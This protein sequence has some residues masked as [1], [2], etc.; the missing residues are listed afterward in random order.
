M[1]LVIDIETNGLLDHMLDY[2]SFPYKLNNKARLWCVVLRNIDTDEVIAGVGKELTR[3]WF[4]DNL[5]QCTELIAHNGVKFDFLVLRLFGLLDYKI[6]FFGQ[7]STIFGKEVQ[8]VDTLVWSRLFYPDRFGG[9]G[10]K[11]WGERFGDHKGDFKQFDRYSQEMLDYCIQDTKVTKLVY[12]KL[13]RE[14]KSGFWDKS[15]AVE[16]KLAD[17][18]INREQYGFR[19]DTKLAYQCVEDLNNKIE[20]LRNKVNPL[21]PEKTLNKG[22]AK[23]LTPPVEKFKKDGN[24]TKNFINF[25]ERIGGE[26]DLETRTFNYD[27][28]VYPI[29]FNGCLKQTIKADIDDQDHVKMHMMNLGWKPTEWRQRNLVIDTSKRNLPY[30]K[31]IE[32]LNRWYND[33]INGKYTE[34]RF[35]EF[36]VPRDKLYDYLAEKLKE[37][38]P[39]FVPTSPSVKVTTE[40]VLCPDLVRLADKIEFAKYFALYTTYKHRRSSILGGDIDE[41]GNPT[42]GYLS[43]VRADGRI[44]TPA[45]EVGTNTNRYRHIG[46]CNIPRPS[47]IY[48][49]E[50]R[51]LFTCNDDEYELGFDFSSLENR[52]QGHHVL[53]YFGG[54]ELARLLIADKP[55]DLHTINAKKLG[56]SRDDA[57]SFTYAILYGGQPRKLSKMLGIS[58]AEAKD[59]YERFWDAV[60]ALK[61]LKAN[62]EKFWASTGKLYI[63][64]IDGRKIFTRQKHSLLNA[65]FQSN[66]V[67]SV[68]Y[69]IVKMFEYFEN[70]GYT[71]SPFDGQPDVIN[72]I[73][74]HDES[75]LAVRKTFVSFKVFDSE[76]EAENY[77][78]EFGVTS[79]FKPSS[80]GHAKKWYF[81]EPN[82]IS[83]VIE[84]SI[85]ETV[86]FLKLR[87][88]LGYEWV[89]HKNWGGAH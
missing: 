34:G 58:L 89:V 70:M 73:D 71:I 25:I 44:P 75:Q 88:P 1:R 82:E 54:E 47:S 57:K 74:Y 23:K 33:T 65:L 45:I 63:T 15:Y 53:K 48:G 3:Q 78:K 40:K 30:E 77:Q 10:L 36:D 20:D 79:E 29:S 22:E 59:L 50:L 32:A 21:L 49:T 8:I 26:I 16:L 64:A 80:V 28:V 87:V 85:N 37:D 14:Y 69:T 11:A 55:N 60:P 83:K 46:V 84:T 13:L 67:I 68:K 42:K 27:G 6:G 5:S 4:V 72:M 52:V 35:G 18:G 39:V 38:K 41:D 24:L 56:I 31:R 62:L 76:E 66:G 12:L 86:E 9:H 2:S 43:M 17:L 7:P 61:E 81:C 19:F 51:S